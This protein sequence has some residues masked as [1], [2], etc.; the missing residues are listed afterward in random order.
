MDP[1]TE[2]KLSEEEINSYSQELDELF[3]SLIPLA[4]ESTKTSETSDGQAS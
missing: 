2:H 1:G 3:Q 4:D